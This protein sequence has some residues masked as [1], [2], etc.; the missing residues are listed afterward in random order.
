VLQGGE[1]YM[2]GGKFR[3]EDDVVFIDAS[4]VNEYGCVCR[5]V[6]DRGA[7]FGVGVYF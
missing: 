3:S 7:Q 4:S 6:Y 5:F 2:Y 1:G